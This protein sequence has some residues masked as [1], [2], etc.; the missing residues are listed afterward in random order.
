MSYSCEKQVSDPSPSEPCDVSNFIIVL[1]V[2][3]NFINISLSLF[4][5][6][7]VYINFIIVLN[8]SLFIS[9]RS[10][11]QFYHCPQYF[12]VYI[13]QAGLHNRCGRG[14]SDICI[15]REASEALES[16]EVSEQVAVSVRYDTAIFIKTIIKS[17]KLIKPSKWKVSKRT[18]KDISKRF[19][20]SSRSLCK[21][22]G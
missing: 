6:F 2:Y 12:I 16:S 9:S 11:Q 5:Y 18:V 21:S 15:G 8:I 13:K 20:T 17:R 3:I 10:A 19:G 4:H 1:I 22:H 7:I 14:Q